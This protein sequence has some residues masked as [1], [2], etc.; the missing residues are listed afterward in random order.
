ML[1]YEINVYVLNKET[2]TSWNKKNVHFMKNKL[3]IYE[4][5]K[6]LLHK[7]QKYVLHEVHFHFMKYTST[8]WNKAKCTNCVFQDFHDEV[9][10]RNSDA[11]RLS[12][13]VSTSESKLASHSKG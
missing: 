10:S 9:A 4:I 8:S 6:I 12:K 7:I 11:D 2:L 13:L 5:K 3:T 1:L